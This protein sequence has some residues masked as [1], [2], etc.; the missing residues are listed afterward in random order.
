MGVDRFDVELEA[1]LADRQWF[2]KRNRLSYELEIHGPNGI[3][4]ITDERLAEIRFTVAYA[5]NNK[6]PA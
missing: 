2:V 4:P 5:S 6:E 1:W 3:I